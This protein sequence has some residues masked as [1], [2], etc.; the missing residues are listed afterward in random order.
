MTESK[1][2]EIARKK[3]GGG[4]KR[5]STLNAAEV[6]AADVRP[7]PPHD[8]QQEEQQPEKA[9]HLP[10]VTYPRYFSDSQEY[11]QRGSGVSE[12]YRQVEV[13]VSAEPTVGIL[14][15]ELAIDGQVHILYAVCDPEVVHAARDDRPQF[16][17]PA[18]NGR[19][20]E[21]EVMPN[22]HTH[23]CIQKYYY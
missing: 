10:Q 23:P 7:H 9:V 1:A 17:P 20:G 11:L 21:W 3:V 15:A 16:L 19:H 8:H 14:E 4:K 12:P 5:E 2:S 18:V 6:F 13:L 22:T